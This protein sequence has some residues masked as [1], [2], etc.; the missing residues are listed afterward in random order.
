MADPV[1]AEFDPDK[2][3]SAMLRRNVSF[4]KLVQEHGLRSRALGAWLARE[5]TPRPMAMA[6]LCRI[7]GVGTDDLM[8]TPQKRGTRKR[9][10]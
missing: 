5:S 10:Q 3:W 9:S 4:R 1:Y 6:Q 7:L 8:T 2:L